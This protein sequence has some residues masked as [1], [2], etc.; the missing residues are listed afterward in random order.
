MKRGRSVLAATLASV[1][2]PLQALTPEE[3]YTR[4]SPSIWFVYGMDSSEKRVSQ[5]SGVVIGPQRVVTNCHVIRGASTVFIRKENVLY[6]AKV[7]YRDPARDLC[8]LQVANLNAPSVEVGTS[9]DV[10][11]GQ[12]VF[13]LGNPQGFEV[14]LSDGLVSALRGPDG[15]ESIIQT[16]AP[17]SQGSSGGGLFNEDGKLVGITTLQSRTG[18]N[19]NFAIPGEWVTELAQRM[20]AQEESKATQ[21]AAVRAGGVAYNPAAAGLPVP[22]ATWKYRYRDLMYRNEQV[23]TV[24]VTGVDGWAVSE[25]FTLQ[26]GSSSQTQQSVVGAE[27]LRF[28]TRG[29][30]ASRTLVE[31]A[32]YLSAAVEKLKPSLQLPTP[33]GYPVD[34][35]GDWNVTGT[36]ARDV[37]VKYPGGEISSIRVDLRGTRPLPDSTNNWGAAAHFEIKAW[38]S[39]ETRRLVRLESRVLTYK[40]NPMSDEVVELLEASGG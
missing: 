33:T 40:S 10:R 15:K 19:L 34:R 9:K 1:A 26:G 18:Q 3:L 25:T 36:V 13:A 17:I 5:G 29:L 7:E 21:L 6:I 8:Q 32:P 14:S 31:F 37:M 30:S 22:G 39:A 38:Y 28:F 4:L 27:E 2:F 20:K 23:Y 16:T 11:V 35:H 12:K 24:K